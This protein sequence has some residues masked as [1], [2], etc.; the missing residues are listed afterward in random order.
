MLTSRWLAAAALAAVLSGCT[1]LYT[2]MPRYGRVRP[3]PVRPGAPV[4]AIEAAKGNLPWPV[5]GT[6]VAGFGAKENPK[7]GTKTRS[8]GITIACRSGSAVCAV[9]GGRVSYA[10]QFMGMGRMVILEH[11]GGFHSVYARLAEM[12]VTVGARVREGQQIG[13]SSDTLHFELRVGGKP[14]DP[15]EWLG[16]R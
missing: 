7:Y 4:H 15:L 5:Q 2:S 10:D 11:G 6:V 14:V 8:L 9:G 1:F 13:T 12:I 16:P 3:K